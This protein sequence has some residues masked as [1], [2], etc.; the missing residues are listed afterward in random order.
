MDM[1]CRRWPEL[2]SLSGLLYATD[3]TAACKRCGESNL[4]VDCIN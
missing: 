2:F 4:Y 3:A 1:M